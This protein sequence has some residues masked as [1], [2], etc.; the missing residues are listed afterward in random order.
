M[1]QTPAPAALFQKI[2]NDDGT[3]GADETGWPF[4]RWSAGDWIAYYGLDVEPGIPV[5]L[6]NLD[7]RSFNPQTRHTSVTLFWSSA[8]ALPELSDRDLEYVWHGL[9]GVNADEPWFLAL[10]FDG[11][12]RDVIAALVESGSQELRLIGT[13]GEDWHIVATPEVA[14]LYLNG[15]EFETIY[16]D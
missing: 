16:L 11:D 12:V 2:I 7:V 10:S 6:Q 5:V 13:H 1:A 15:L 14:T 8:F 3:P 9:P 4:G